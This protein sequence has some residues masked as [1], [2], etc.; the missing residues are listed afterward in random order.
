MPTKVL[1]GSRKLHGADAGNGGNGHG[2]RDRVK[3]CAKS[4]DAKLLLV[5]QEI[6]R[7]VEASQDGRLTERGQGRPV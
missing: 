2:N 1:N 5:S 7:L 4:G 3:Q 6:M